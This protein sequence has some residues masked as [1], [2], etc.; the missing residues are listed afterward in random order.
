MILLVMPD[1]GACRPGLVA[2]LDGFFRRLRQ[3]G[4]GVAGSPC[5]CHAMR[6]E[7]MSGGPMP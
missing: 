2:G 5:T 1:A 4:L 3:S 7:K 6:V